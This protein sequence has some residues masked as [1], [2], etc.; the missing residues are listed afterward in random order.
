MLEGNEAVQEKFE[1]RRKTFFFEIEGHDGDSRE[2][3]Y[4]QQNDQSV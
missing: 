1:H 4:R 3:I 2:K